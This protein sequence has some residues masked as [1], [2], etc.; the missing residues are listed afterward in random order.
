MKV[1]VDRNKCAGI[2]LCEGL[3]PDLFEVGDDGT[4]A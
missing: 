2:G 3:S 4:P 1:Q